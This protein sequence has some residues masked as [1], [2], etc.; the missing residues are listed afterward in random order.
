LGLVD[1]FFAIDPESAVARCFP[2]IDD[3]NESVVRSVIEAFSGRGI[4]EPRVIAAYIRLLESYDGSFYHPAA[5][6]VD[7]LGN[8]GP[9]ARESVPA[10]Q[11]LAKAPNISDHL[12]EEIANAL[13][14]IR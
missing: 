5:S 11:E 9:A 7:A 6:A 1:A 10:L 4:S 3:E 8:L 13:R 12:K 14:R 2:L